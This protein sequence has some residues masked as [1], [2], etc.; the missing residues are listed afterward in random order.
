MFSVGG[1]AN[2]IVHA[3]AEEADGT[4]WIAGAFTTLDGQARSRVAKLDAAGA[5][6]PSFAPPSGFSNSSTVNCIVPLGAGKVLIGCQSFGS[7]DTYRQGIVR[8]NANGSVDTSFNAGP[9]VDGTV[10][11][12]HLLPDGRI[13]VAGAFTKRVAVLNA[14]GSPDPAFNPGTGASSTV[15]T[16]EPLP[17]GKFMVGGSFST[18][19]G[20]SRPYLCR[21][22]ADGSVDTT[23]GSTG[24][25]PSG[26]V[27]DIATD[28]DGRLLVG[29][30]FTNYQG[31]SHKY[32]VRIAE[33][34]TSDPYFLPNL[35]SSVRAI[36]PLTDGRTLIV[37]DFS[38]INDGAAQG[39]ALLHADG[40][41]DAT[42]DSANGAA[43]GSVRAVKRLADGKILLGGSFATVAGGASKNYA[44]L[45]AASPPMRPAV[46]SI[47]PWAAEAGAVV[48]MLGSNFSQLTALE[49]AGNVPAQFTRISETEIHVTVPEGALAGFPRLIGLSETAPAGV[50]FVPLPVTPGTVDPSFD[51]GSGASSSVHALA[52]DSLGRVLIAGDFSSVNNVARS[53]IARLLPNGVVDG[54]FSPPTNTTYPRAIAVQTDGK[55]LVGGSTIASRAGI[56]RFLEDG[57][58]DPSFSAAGTAASYV[59]AIAIQGDGRILIGGSFTRRIARLLPDGSADLSFDVGAGFPSTVNALRIQP[60]GKIL[61]GG[62]FSTYNGVNARYVTRLL[63][64]GRLDSTFQVTGTGLSGGVDAL[65]LQADGSILIGGDFNSINGNSAFGDLARLGPNGALDQSFKPTPG[66]TVRSVEITAD[67]RIA[68]GGDFV[69]IGGSSR[70]YAALLHADG[71]VVT[72]FNTTGGPSSSIN[73]VLAGPRGG[74]LIGGNFQTI[75]GQAPRY[76][77]LLG[78]DGGKTRPAIASLSR[79]SGVAGERLQVFGSNLGNLTSAEFSGGVAATIFPISATTAELE[80]PV[81]AMNGPITVRNAFGSGTSP[82]FF[83]LRAAPLPVVA[84]IP[85]GSVAIGSSFAVTGENFYD[86]TAVRIGVIAASFVVHSATSMTVTVPPNALTAKVILTGPGGTA[87]STADLTVVKPPPAFTNAATSTGRIGQSF[88]FDLKTTFGPAAFIA[89]PLPAGLVL[90]PAT[91]RISGIPRAA[92]VTTVVTSATNDGGTTFGSLEITIS[93][94]P[95]PTIASISPTEIV[96]GGRI[97]VAGTFLFQTTTVTVGGIAA[98]FEVLADNRIAVV[99]PVGVDSGVVQVTTA[100][101]SI[102]STASVSRWD[103]QAGSQTV[104]GFGNP[105][106]GQSSPPFGLDHAIAV[107]AGEHH[108]LALL[109][110]GRIA[111]WGANWAGQTTQPSGILPAIAIAAGGHH[112]LALQADGTVVAWGRNDEGQCSGASSLS[113]IAAISAGGFHSL[114]LTRLGTVQAWGSNT[115]GQINV[116]ANLGGVVAIAAGGNFS[117]ALKS[118]GSVVAWGDASLG[119]TEVPATATDIVAITVGMGHVVAL[120]ADGT[121]VGWGANWA[122]QLALPAATAS[123]VI[124]ISAG[125]HHTIALR[126]DGSCVAWGANWNGQSTEPVTTTAVAVAAGGDHSLILH[127]ASPAPR[128]SSVRIATGQPGQAFSLAPLAENGPSTFTAQGLPPGLTVNPLT[129]EITGT[130]TRGG[131]SLA[132]L[133]ARN[134]HGIS[135]HSLRVFIGPYLVGW[136]SSIPGPLPQALAEVVHVAAGS[137]HCLALHRNRTVTSWGNNS[138]GQLNIP[139]GLNNVIAIEAGSQFSIALKS[140][141]TVIAWGRP[142]NGSPYA[143]S[144]TQIASGVVAI[145]AVGTHAN[146]LMANGTARLIVGDSLPPSFGSDL[147]DLAA[148]SGLSSFGF[149]NGAVGINRSGDVLNL[150]GSALS[151]GLNFDRVEISSDLFGYRFTNPPV[152]A[153]QR[154]GALYEFQSDYFSSDITRILRTETSNAVELATGD[155]FAVALNADGTAIALALSPNPDDFSSPSAAPQ[156]TTDALVNVGAIAATEGYAIAVKEPFTRARFA[157]L[158]VIEG[159]VGHSFN[160]RLMTTSG[161]P[162]FSASQLPA[163]LSMG[164]NG[165][166]LGTP[167]TA[168]TFNFVAIATYPGYFISQVVSAKFTSGNAPVDLRLTAGTL[169]ENLPVGT[170]VGTLATTDYD[171]SETF[172]YSLVAGPGATDNSKFKISGNQLLTNAVLD[173]EAKPLLS[174]RVQVTDSGRNTFARVFQISLSNVLTDDDDQDGLTEAQELQLGTSPSSRDTDQDGAADG[175]EIAMGTDPLSAA[176][177]PANYVA[178]WGLNT[179]GRCNVPTDLGPVIAVAAGSSH[180]LALKADGTVAA[181]G[182]NSYGQCDVPVGLHQVVSVAAGFY[183]SVALKADGTV[184]AWGSPT[185]ATVP[186]D[187]DEVIEIA[188]NGSN[189]AALRADGQVVVWGSSSYS[190]TTVPAAAAG[191]VQISVGNDFLLALNRS[192]STVGWGY[193]TQSTLSGPTSRNDLATVAAGSSLSLGLTRDARVQA[194]GSTSSNALKIPV[195]LD[196]VIR[197]SAGSSFS[198]ATRADGQLVAWGSNTH[199]QSTV[200]PGL[201]PV[202][203]AEAGASHAV[204][205]VGSSPPEQFVTTAVRTV[206]GLPVFHQLAFSG[207]A[208][209]FSARFLPPGLSFDS[210]TGS[211]VGVPAQQGTFN[212]RVTAEKGYSHISEIITVIC[213]NPRRFA[214]WSAVHFPGSPTD[215]HADPDGDSASNF[216]EYALARNPAS[217]DPAP[218]VALTTVQVN[219]EAFPALTYSRNR[220]ATDVRWTVEVS[221]DLTTWLPRTTTVSITRQGEIDLVTVRDTMPISATQPRFMRLKAE[222]IAPAP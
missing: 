32:L 1:G 145:G 38:S 180:T 104:T 63:P 90:N 140:D 178:A 147:I 216:L 85:A 18:F 10:H 146:A 69:S 197:I 160:H 35:N 43:D 93:L 125:N 72:E 222:S 158:R 172:S 109:A 99:M 135:H 15:F 33:D 121:L 80:V 156:P 198:L 214:E 14:E 143:I 81:G 132:T 51:V 89:D 166:I 100:Q 183:H 34:G 102:T 108:S 111:G 7:G 44:K 67:G 62:D 153:I 171:P 131:D 6:D 116:P 133:T 139:S 136:G 168:G 87:Q 24:S 5:V 17:S 114:A 184:V 94:P 148:P 61:V 187:L 163:G 162:V 119:Q 193:E 134:G 84:S 174:I 76:I 27:H 66:S 188:A 91:G 196:A 8:L 186:A 190:V 150:F 215:P 42:F 118:D 137:N 58:V 53:S 157:S 165:L 164:S 142:P 161:A 95:P 37:G 96:P 210:G 213:E 64:D 123:P 28:A 177:K 30:V 144:G 138:F 29:G 124:R 73:A 217:H 127:A 57:S 71:G 182:G 65:A 173:F 55:I 50:W 9:T 202:Q 179:D 207:T 45:L 204:A 192:G 88:T 23:F 151:S 176:S 54:T 16:V 128:I 13:L 86:V 112:S 31:R 21:L 105:V 110:D 11:A 68:V 120:K 97:I 26:T 60:D 101:G 59:Y 181:W 211:I 113:N 195:D 129:G 92:G 130:P 221:S 167:T 20:V 220:N 77:A 159:R 175:L 40:K 194:W 82:Q 149:S 22:H 169:E 4:L 41:P 70:N 219:G 103:F 117:V 2:D 154:G 199:Q 75:S 201:G 46:G 49:F 212:I 83:R 56:A 122:G 106:S 191:S 155:Q 48:R 200:P 74:L 115:F 3:V 12:I 208:D 203:M 205:L 206:V 79:L 98:D 170:P 39:I 19:N 209:R 152:F 25:G 36:S 218:P 189:S 185:Y 52:R 78:G 107:A 47:F 126:A 141:G